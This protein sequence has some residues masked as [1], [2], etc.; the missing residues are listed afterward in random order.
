MSDANDTWF[1]WSS[2]NS[3]H[4]HFHR[5]NL[6]EKR[7]SSPLSVTKN[8]FEFEYE[9]SFPQDIHSFV[10]ALNRWFE[11]TV[12]LIHRTVLWRTLVSLQLATLYATATWI[13]F[14]IPLPWLY[15]QWSLIVF[16]CHFTLPCRSTRQIANPL[17]FYLHPLDRLTFVIELWNTS[18]RESINISWVVSMSNT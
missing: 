8:H 16:F 1:C 12:G 3:L 7:C 15:Q 18:T 4:E 17:L 2:E 6:N 13:P 14:K 11:S 9:S 10:H 5:L